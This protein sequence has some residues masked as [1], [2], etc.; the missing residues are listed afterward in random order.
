MYCPKCNAP[1]PDNALACDVC[2]EHFAVEEQRGK[3][4]RARAKS[5]DILAD[6]FHS[7][8]FLVLCIFLSVLCG[9]SILYVLSTLSFLSFQSFVFAF[10][11]VSMIAGWQLYA[12]HGRPDA[13]KIKNFKSI[14]TTLKVI[15]K[16]TYIML[17]I[18]AAFVLI[19]AL[20]MSAFQSQFEDALNDPELIQNIDSYLAEFEIELPFETSE[21]V[22]FILSASFWIIVCVVC[23]IV[24]GCAIALYILLSSAF[25]KSET[26][27]KSLED[28]CATGQYSATNCPNQFIFVMGIICG[29]EALFNSMNFTLLLYYAGIS[30]LLITTS[31]LFKQLHAKQI[32]NNADIAKEEAELAR[33]ARLTNE[34]VANMS[35]NASRNASDTTDKE[36]VPDSIADAENTDCTNDMPTGNNNETI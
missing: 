1:L 21:L 20:V 5:T 9:G 10:S 25:K 18:V 8:V 34:Y 29:V 16:I 4:L 33:V 19:F 17:I 35:N 30:G 26:C 3:F 27:V 2:G 31:V 36:P 15:F 28:T 23:I 13:K 7:P 14:Y 32:Q 24:I 11:L 22:D 12:S 6:A